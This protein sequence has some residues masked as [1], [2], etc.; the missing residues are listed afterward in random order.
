[1]A[2]EKMGIARN[3]HWYGE[4]VTSKCYGVNLLESQYNKGFGNERGIKQ[5]CPLG[6]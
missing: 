4:I 1:M 3:F 6:P 5:G 2:L